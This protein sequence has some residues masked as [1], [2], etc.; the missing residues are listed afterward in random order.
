MNTK[1]T[2]TG[3]KAA[4]KKVEKA[5]EEKPVYNEFGVCINCQGGIEECLHLNLVQREDGT[6]CKDCGERI[7]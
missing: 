3:K 5:P 6:Y 4:S 2:T 7:S 1:K